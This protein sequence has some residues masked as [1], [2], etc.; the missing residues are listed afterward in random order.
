MWL[1]SF[2]IMANVM[3]KILFSRILLIHT[4]IRIKSLKVTQVWRRM[5]RMKQKEVV[6]LDREY[7]FNLRLHFCFCT[8]LKCV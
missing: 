3:L 7:I 6:G 4:Q 8:T 2:Q 1:V 5:L